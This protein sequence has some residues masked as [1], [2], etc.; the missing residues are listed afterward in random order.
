MTERAPSDPTLEALWKNTLDHW[1]DE[2][3]HVA[4]LDYCQQSD[5][6]V[7]AAVYYR[8]MTGDHERGATAK[9]HLTRLTL[10]ALAKLDASRSVAQ[11]S[12][13][14]NPGSWLLIISFLA[15]TVGLLLYMLGR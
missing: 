6:L 4:L 15:A 12:D 11:R 9:Q 8:G 1:D 2:A 7:Q 5:Q 14:L 13:S 10:L 3:T